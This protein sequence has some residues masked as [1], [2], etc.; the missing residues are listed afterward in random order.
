M[1]H[2]KEVVT[3]ILD[4]LRK[5]DPHIGLY[6]AHV[7]PGYGS[8]INLVILSNGKLQIPIDIL[9]DYEHNP[10]RI[11]PERIRTLAKKFRD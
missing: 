9:K 7:D 6:M 10:E 11:T 5:Y 2:S 8:N 1:I 3:D 4:L